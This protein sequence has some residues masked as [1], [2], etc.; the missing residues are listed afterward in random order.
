MLDLEKMERLARARL[1]SQ[2]HADVIRHKSAVRGGF[3]RARVQL[4]AP[5]AARWE[6]RLTRAFL[7]GWGEVQV[8]AHPRLSDG[9]AVDVLEFVA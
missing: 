3:M 9:G 2:L 8:V 6:L 7:P 5:N 4:L 1:A